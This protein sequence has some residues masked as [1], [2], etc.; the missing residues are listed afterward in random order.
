MVSSLNEFKG[1]AGVIGQTMLADDAATGRQLRL[2]KGTTVVATGTS[3]ADGFYLLN[4]KHKG[5][6]ENF[7]AE[8]VGSKL[9]QVV[10]LKANGYAEVN[11]DLLT[12]TV[13]TEYGSGWAPK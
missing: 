1:I 6:A 8:I 3:D 4:Y 11:W 5:K 2:L 10:T 13:T 12:G 7:T 9:K